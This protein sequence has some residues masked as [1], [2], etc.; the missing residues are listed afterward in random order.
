MS[1]D[2]SSKASPPALRRHLLLTGLHASCKR[3]SRSPMRKPFLF[4]FFSSAAFFRVPPPHTSLPGR[5]LAPSLPRI[6]SCL[7]D[8][9]PPRPLSFWSFR[10]RSPCRTSPPGPARTP[11][12]SRSH[13]PSEP[14]GSGGLC[15]ACYSERVA[16]RRHSSP[17]WAGPLRA[18]VRRL[19][20]IHYKL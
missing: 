19:T 3:S 1:P 4:L 16:Q 6:Y 10:T 20:R 12:G 18:A 2:L 13:P 14:S 11:R 5:P 9:F 7:P 8:A 15:K 17:G